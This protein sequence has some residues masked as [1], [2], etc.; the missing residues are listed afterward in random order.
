MQR[1]LE[2]D[3]NEILFNAFLNSELR[4]FVVKVLIFLEI[5]YV[6]RCDEGFFS[7]I[8]KLTNQ[9]LQIATKDIN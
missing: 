6:G 1:F 7:F 2:N 3:L 9:M 8:L 5:N 4:L